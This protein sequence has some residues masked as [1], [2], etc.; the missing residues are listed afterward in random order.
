MGIV[1]FSDV[2]NVPNISPGS[3]V[4]NSTL[5]GFSC[6]DSLFPDYFNF[7]VEVMSDGWPYWTDSMQVIITGVEDEETI[8]TEFALE[9][10]YPNPFNPSTIISWQSPVGSWQTLKI[11]DVLGNEIM[12]L[13]D[14]Y[15]PAGRYEVDFN[16]STFTS[17]VYFYQLKAGEYTAVKKMILLK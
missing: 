10:N 9:Q 7:K 8:P 17:G 6:I 1:N 11:Y 14:E 5:L 16:A 13:I 12:T 4:S 2:V 15:K 3:V